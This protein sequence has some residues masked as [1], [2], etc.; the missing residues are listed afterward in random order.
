MPDKDDQPKSD[1]P[2]AQVHEED[3]ISLPEQDQYHR[4]VSPLTIRILAINFMALVMLVGGVLYLNQFRENLMKNRI[5]ALMIEAEIISG[6]LGEAASSGPEAIEVDQAPAQQIISRLVGPTQNRARLF[7]V[8]GRLLVDSRLLGGT[9]NLYS[10]PLPAPGDEAKIGKRLMA[11]L[12]NFLDI[13]SGQTDVPKY[14]ERPGQ[15]AE[16]Y[17]EV[18]A[19]LEGSPS[20]QVRRLDENTLVINVAVPVQRFRRV[21]GAFLLTTDTEDIDRIVRDEQISI[22]KVFA[23]IMA[24]TTFLSVFLARTVVLPIRILARASERVR[25]GIGRE[26]RIPEFAER[27]DEIGDLSRAL[28]AMTRALYHQIDAIE[29]F[30]ADVAHE[31]KNPLSSMRSALETIRMT[32]KPEIREKLLAIL[33]DDV[34]RLDRLITDISDASR[35]DA[36][37][38][39]GHMTE[40]D[41]VAMLTTLVD[42]YDVTK[43][44]DRAKVVFKPG[45]VGPFIVPGIEARLSQVWRNLI[46]NAISFTPKDKTI[47]ISCENLGPLIVVR[48]DD[49]G[50]GMPEGAETNIFERFYSERPESESFGNHSGLGLAISKQIVEAHGG[51]ISARNLPDPSDAKKILGARFAVR[52]P[53]KA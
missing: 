48:V 22:L 44:K 28:G 52:L 15:R 46:D 1:A 6:A 31:L 10:E 8:S 2:S 41:L 38:S 3:D 45:L 49:E 29:S 19:A 39:R 11:L 21:L 24:V 53:V 42:A 4:L 26:E 18:M 7:A 33:D 25:R 32:N 5:D 14:Q 34:K 12:Y 43:K 30:A 50:P 9:G 23:T 47:T 40:I 36:E 37:L 20:V 27:N 51:L 16:D 17:L 13:W 35:L